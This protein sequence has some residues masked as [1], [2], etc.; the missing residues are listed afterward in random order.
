M[1]RPVTLMRLRS[2]LIRRA[3]HTIITL[4]V[5]LILLF[6][7]FRMM[8]G[9][10][11]RFFIEPGQPP[12][13][14]DRLLVEF[15]FSR[16][17]DAPGIFRSGS[18]N[19]FEVGAYGIRIEANSTGVVEPPGLY[20][21]TLYS[22]YVRERRYFPATD[23]VV[24]WNVTYSEA[25]SGNI[26]VGETFN[27]TFDVKAQ[28]PMAN[29]VVGLT[30]VRNE[31]PNQTTPLNLSSSGTPIGLSNF[32]VRYS[33]QFSAAQTGFY[34]MDISV[35]DPV[36]GMTE[37]IEHGYAINPADITPFNLVEDEG[38]LFT[39]RNIFAE[40]I[41]GLTIAIQVEDGGRLRPLTDD[42]L[43]AW[44]TAPNGVVSELSP[45]D[46]L[47]HPQVVVDLPVWEQFWEYFAD[48]MTLDFGLWFFR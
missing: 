18:F 26:T 44:V 24:I 3:L 40:S 8:P 6:I 22:S 17:V 43:I 21:V 13:V 30:I 42:S 32:W 16:W 4:V 46:Q 35:T 19:A 9:D 7:I 27:L 47:T 28:A 36:L 39:A 41:G 45:P 1:F 5:I 33:H 11:T 23:P 15:G 25:P 2:F 38:G 10:P 29:R 20:N 14:R 12:D 34:R 37:V 31:D 48:M